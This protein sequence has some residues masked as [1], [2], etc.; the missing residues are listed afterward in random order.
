MKGSGG[1]YGT[2]PEQE[3][4]GL[5]QKLSGASAVTAV[6]QYTKLSLYF[7]KHVL[8][9]ILALWGWVS[10]PLYTGFPVV[11]LAREGLIASKLNLLP[12]PRNLFLG[13]F[14][15]FFTAGLH[16]LSKGWKPICIQSLSM[17]KQLQCPL[18]W[19]WGLTE[20]QTEEVSV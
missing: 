6:P 14:F 10:R 3:T 11:P 7:P 9:I 12:A 16:N 17:K 4:H 20:F 15:N 8:A 13:F 19:V 1:H 2:C 5:G 18:E